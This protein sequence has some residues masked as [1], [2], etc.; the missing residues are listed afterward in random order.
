MSLLLGK[1]TVSFGLDLVEDRLASLTD[2]PPYVS[3]SYGSDN[4]TPC[5]AVWLLPKPEH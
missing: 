4:G 5:G 2:A 1:K 3:T